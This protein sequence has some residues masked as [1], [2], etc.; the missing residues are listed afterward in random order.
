VV[1]VNEALAHRFWPNEDAVGRRIRS[2]S[3]SYEVIGVVKGSKLRSVGETTRLCLF[4]SLLQGYRRAEVPL[5]TTLIVRTT[6]EPASMAIAIVAQVRRVDRSL[7]TFNIQTMED[8]LTAAL[9][10]PRWGAALFGLF[11]LVGLLLASVGLYGVM[12]YS[13][14]QRTREI[15]IRL[16]LGA[17]SFGIV[18]AV[19]ARGALL[20]WTG[21][22]LGLAAAFGLTR[23]LSS[24]LYGVSTKDAATFV[25]VPLILTVVTILASY[26]PARSAAHVEPLTAL[27]QA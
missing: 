26:V 5:G 20:A 14:R 23:F 3:H 2:G 11:G 10:F 13:V 12:A 25:A 4:R 15:G 24:L 8:H 1:I 19:V 16:A 17:E 9:L 22:A 7:A 6:A 21:V 18:R 27:R